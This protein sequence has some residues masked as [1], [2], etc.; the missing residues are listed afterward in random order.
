MSGFDSQYDF[1]MGLTPVIEVEPPEGPTV[2]VMPTPGPQGKDGENGDP[3]PPGDGAAEMPV[4][5]TQL[6][7]NAL[8][9]E[10]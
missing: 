6:F 1:E 10:N 9:Q 5:P 4:S 3:G 8:A 7:E 2:I